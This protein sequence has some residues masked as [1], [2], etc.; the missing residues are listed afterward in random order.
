M[1]LEDASLKG[2]TTRS[3][4]GS[5]PVK[6]IFADGAGAAAG[7]RITVR[8][9]RGTGPVLSGIARDWNATRACPAE[10][11]RSSGWRLSRRCSC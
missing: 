1:Y 10:A 9:A 5:F 6:E 8:S 11:K 3:K 2:A 4:D 7:T